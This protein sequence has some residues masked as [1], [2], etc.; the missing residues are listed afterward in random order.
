MHYAAIHWNKRFQKLGKVKAKFFSE[1]W[2][3]SDHSSSD[4]W[5]NVQILRE[6]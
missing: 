4:W 1:F 3:K 5:P 2:S 6:K